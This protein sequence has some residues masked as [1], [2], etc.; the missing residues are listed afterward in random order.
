MIERLQK[1]ITRA[2]IA[3][4]ECQMQPAR[5]GESPWH[6]RI[7]LRPDAECRD[8]KALHNRTGSLSAR[9]HKPA[10]AARDQ[11]LGN[12]GHGGFNQRTSSIAPKF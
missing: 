2:E 1:E 7:N 10:D 8:T 12:R 11:P 5:F 9:H 3:G 4:F 6:A